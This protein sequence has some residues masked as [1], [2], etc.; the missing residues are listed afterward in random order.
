MNMFNRIIDKKLLKGGEVFLGLNLHGD[1]NEKK[2][3]TPVFSSLH[4][5]RSARDIIFKDKFV[6]CNYKFN[7]FFNR[8]INSARCLSVKNQK[9]TTIYN[10]GSFDM[11]FA[12][13]LSK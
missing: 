5:T 8:H 7:S 2:A 4:R 3:Q 13:I 6:E 11:P 9:S 10:S 12:S 1:K